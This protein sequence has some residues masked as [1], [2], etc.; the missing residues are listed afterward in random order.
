MLFD[1]RHLRDRKMNY[2]SH[3][4]FALQV[5]L[6]MLVTILVLTMHAIIP[7]VRT[8]KYFHILSLSNYLYDCDFKTRTGRWP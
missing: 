6:R 3:M 2:L 1:W 8:P 4:A 5:I 7:W